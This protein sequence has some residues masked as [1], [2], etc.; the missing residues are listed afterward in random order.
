MYATV[1]HAD[2]HDTDEA[3]R[4]LHETVIPQLK[5]APGFV[6]AYF[7]RVDEGHGVS[8]VVFETEEQ[9]RSGG[10]PEGATAPGVTLAKLQIGEVIGSA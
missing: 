9:A 1:V 5:Q 7:V 2:I 3:T 6:A 8:V 4:G 10:P